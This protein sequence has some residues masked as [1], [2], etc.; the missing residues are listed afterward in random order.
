MQAVREA[1]CGDKLLV[2]IYKKGSCWDGDIPPASVQER[3]YKSIDKTNLRNCRLKLEERIAYNFTDTDYHIV[4]TISDA[5]YSKDYKRIR[6]FFRAFLGRLR[7]RRSIRGAVMPRYVYVI[8]G[9]HEGGRLHIHQ[10]MSAEDM[11]WSELKSCW[12]CGEVFYT[13]IKDHEHRYHLGQYLTKEPAKL[14]KMCI[15]QNLF[16]A[17]H[18][19]L[20]PSVA[21]FTLPDERSYKVPEGY[22]I[23]HTEQII[24]E[25]GDCL[26]YILK[27]NCKH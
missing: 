27:R 5:Y 17:S 25:C 12:N 15:D 11:D 21:K 7:Y 23:V 1:N 10:L 14:G 20:K 8:E 4:F 6:D 18:S 24:D 16:V 13:Q 2:T 19:C 3:R 9:Q 26:Y 22:A